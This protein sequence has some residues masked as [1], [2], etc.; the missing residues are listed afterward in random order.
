M[1]ILFN[2][3]GPIRTICLWF[4]MIAFSLLDDVYDV[5][6]TLAKQT[7]ISDTIINEVLL[8]IYVLVGV[9][10]LFRIAVLLINSMISPDALSKKGAGLSR[11]F[12]N[13]VI[14]I[15]LLVLT[16]KLFSWSRE[17]S[18]EIVDKN[19][20]QRLFVNVND[21]ND[22][23][24]EISPGKEMQ[25]IAI[26]AVITPNEVF[27][28]STSE[29]GFTKDCDGDK[30]CKKAMTC[31][32]EI[33]GEIKPDGEDDCVAED[34]SVKWSNLV[35]NN[36][37]EIGGW[38]EA[39]EYAYNYKPLILTIIGWLITYIF[40]SFSFD[41][42]KRMI[43]LAILE[44]LSPLFIASIVDPK[45]MQSGPFKKWLK[46]VGTSYASLFLRQAAVAIILLCTKILMLWNGTSF[47]RLIVLI[48]T[49][50]FCKSFP[51]WISNMI[52]IDGDGTGLSGLSIG[53][54]LGGAALIGG[55]LTKA[56]HAAAGAA[57][58]AAQAGHNQLR[59]RRADRKA[60]REKEGLDKGVGKKARDARNA[61]YDA[62]KNDERYAGMSRRKAIR[63]A[64]GDAYKEN[65][66]GMSKGGLKAG[67]KQLGASM[68]AG[69]ISGGRAG[70]SASDM[71]GV[72]SGSV[73]AANQFGQEVGLSGK[74]IGQRISD[75][76][77]S[78][79]KSAK[80][81]YGTPADIQD[82]IS[83]VEDTRKF[84][85]YFLPRFKNNSELGNTPVSQGD[86]NKAFLGAKGGT[87]AM[88]A[89]MA[90]KNMP[91]LK[92]AKISTDGN[93]IISV[94]NGSSELKVDGANFQ[95]KDSSGNVKYSGDDYKN[96]VKSGRD[97]F[98]AE[99]LANYENMFAEATRQA[100]SSTIGN[101]T[102]MSALMQ[103]RTSAEQ[104]ITYNTGEAAKV[105]VAAGLVATDGTINIGE[106]KKVSL[107][108]A[109]ID[110]L[111]S[112]FEVAK[113]NNPGKYDDEYASVQSRKDAC[114]KSDRIVDNINTQINY[115]EKSNDLL[116]NMIGTFRGEEG[117]LEKTL[118]ELLVIAEKK[119][120]KK[121]KVVDAYAAQKEVKKD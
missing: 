51:K 118:D 54:K 86:F 37:A 27:V 92:N 77:D 91:E 12:V 4:D 40:L 8:N 65:N 14:M 57:A 16:P 22:S 47:Q 55:A 90:L 32:Q 34:G 80:G 89:A 1:K 119:K 6:A 13:T 120:E 28:D 19:Y 111:V 58:G 50:I 116:S 62:N 114:D 23:S 107:E 60:I 39:K 11:I 100:I 59:A 81:A 24:K 49:L 75:T 74:G 72:F 110:Q 79:Y 102:Q 5:F 2:L 85:S 48:S 70:V 45:S 97:C 35:S 66:A 108:D 83:A 96:Y 53:K 98:T 109:T 82:K 101:N 113:R 63:K 18:N 117:N 112:T 95:I 87:D 26:G 121:Q 94:K 10:A 76:T 99:G 103:Q 30:K 38:L 61:W 3:W 17:I 78:V 106:G 69:V 41:V 9:F 15:V 104:S 67:A 46:A 31:L 42:G 105:A 36:D 64:R 73:K 7:L 52:G 115:Y 56:G 88:Y 29:S 44:I 20:V 25:R 68:V 71:K 93:G 84:D 21:P 33:R 43:E